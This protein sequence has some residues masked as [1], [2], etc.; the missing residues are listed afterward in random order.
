MEPQ[1]R[2]GLAALTQIAFEGLDLTPLRT[3][4]VSQSLNSATRAGALMDLSVIEQIHGNREL[5]M[6]LQ[7]KAF[8]T[9]RLFQTYRPQ[10]ARKKLLIYAA[11]IDMGGNTP[12]EFLVPNDEFEIVTYYSQSKTLTQ[13]A[14]SLPSHDVAFCAAPADA[15]GAEDLFAEVRRISAN[16][17]VKVL[18]LPENLVKPERDTLPDL[19]GRIN[20]LRLPKTIRISRQDLQN[21]LQ[22]QA[23]KEKF[24]EVGDYPYVVRPVGSHAGLGLSKVETREEL[25][26]YLDSRDEGSFFV[27][28]FIDYA[29]AEDGRFKKYRIVLVDGKAFPCHMAISDQWD[30][31]YMNS[32]MRE[33]EAKR[34]EEAAFMDQFSTDFGKR[35]QTNFDALAA[36]IGLDYFG[37][38]CAE[39]ADGNLV[40]FEV[41]NALIVH[42][43]DCAATFPYKKQ[44]MRRIFAAFEQMLR[45][46]CQPLD[47]DKLSIHPSECANTS[48]EHTVFV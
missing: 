47:Q 22:S 27:G 40:V 15:E 23:E 13:D 30:V 16:T 20:G 33:S 29:S 18:N 6:Q 44:H 9:C 48:S 25:I 8:E 10:K 43:M 37:L 24:A 28:E 35:H 36:G 11:P 17:G 26:A 1:P 7:S 46:S 41:D 45:D 14:P 5:G 4:L 31:W 12:V 34:R 19:L 42:D 3:E 21:A 2:L 32:K 38:D 39:D